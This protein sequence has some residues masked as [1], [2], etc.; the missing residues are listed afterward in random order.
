MVRKHRL[1]GNKNVTL[2]DTFCHFFFIEMHIKLCLKMTR[3][4]QH[5]ITR[6]T[7]FVP[8]CSVWQEN[9]FRE[10]SVVPPITYTFSYFLFLLIDLFIHLFLI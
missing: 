1:E 3:N 10:M 7:L 2:K 5:T 6:C 8:T 4:A 9:F